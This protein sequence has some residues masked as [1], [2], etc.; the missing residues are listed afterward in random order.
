MKW[1]KNYQKLSSAKWSN[2]HSLVRNTMYILRK[3]SVCFFNIELPSLLVCCPTACTEASTPL[4]GEEVQVLLKMIFDH[5]KTIS[6][7][8]KEGKNNPRDIQC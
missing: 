1:K 8:R 3:Y 7:F 6:I 5:L 4:Y 2:I